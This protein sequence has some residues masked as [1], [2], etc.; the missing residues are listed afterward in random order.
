M[1]GQGV[2]LWRVRSPSDRSPLT[3]RAVERPR[4]T[5]AGET[6]TKYQCAHCGRWSNLQR[7]VDER[8]VEREEVDG[9]VLISERTTPPD[10]NPPRLLTSYRCPRCGHVHTTLPAP[11]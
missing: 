10:L 9:A 4:R 7:D 1:R 3:I 11:D 8:A 5:Y 6:E 2:A